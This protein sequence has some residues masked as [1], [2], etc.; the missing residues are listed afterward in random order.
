M[1]ILLYGTPHRVVHDLE[2][3]F[4]VLLFIC[5]HL[6]GPQNDISDPPLFG[7]NNDELKHPSPMREWLQQTSF[8][9]LGHL[10][11]SHMAH[12]FELLI[13]P[14]IS[15]YFNPLKPHLRRLWHALHPQITDNVPLGRDGSHSTA[16]PMDVINVFKEALQDPVLVDGARSTKTTLGKRAKP[17]DPSQNPWYPAETD[18]RLLTDDPLVAPSNPG[19]RQQKLLTKQRRGNCKRRRGI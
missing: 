19:R 16:S 8:S 15:P 10:K 9:V 12:H 5:T 6:K 11:Y 18:Q 2:S 1:E 17:G 13:L 3:V 14:H 4:Y 7:N